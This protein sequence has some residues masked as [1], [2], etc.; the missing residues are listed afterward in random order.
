M[1]T[2]TN[3]SVVPRSGCIMISAIGTPATARTM[4]SRRASSSLLKCAISDA[5]VMITMILANSDGCSW[6]GPTW[7]H[8]WL[9]LRSLPRP[10]TTISNSSS[11]PP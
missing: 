4:A 3:T 7:N 10:V 1:P 5:S 2:A 6:N 9:P 11:T 8:A